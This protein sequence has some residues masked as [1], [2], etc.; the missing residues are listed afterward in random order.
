ML[1]DNRENIQNELEYSFLSFFSSK[2]RIGVIGCGRAGE[3]KINHFVKNNCYVEVL[4]RDFSQSILELSKNNDNLKLI[5]RK[6]DYEFLRDKHIVI[7]ALEDNIIR[8]R[9]KEYCDKNYKIYI[10]S[11]DFIEGMAVVP[12]ERSTKTV[13]IALN[14]K[15]GNP[16]GAVW[17]ANKISDIL[18]EFDEYIDF[19]TKLRNRA[20]SI[21]EY[22]SEIIKFIFTDEFKEAFDEGEEIEAMRNRFPEEVIKKLF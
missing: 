22:K 10:D 5:S 13:S 2:L 19:T 3:I 18:R 21:P 14:T 4:S 15:E 16:K 8:E 6:F 11:T 20:K 1:K 9:T 12:T 17:V 7:I